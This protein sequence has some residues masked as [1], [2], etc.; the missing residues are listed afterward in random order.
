MKDKEEEI[1]IPLKYPRVSPMK[2]NNR[3]PTTDPYNQPEIIKEL[4]DS[5]IY[6]INRNN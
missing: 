6:K 1:I 3:I 2:P 5:S 4:A